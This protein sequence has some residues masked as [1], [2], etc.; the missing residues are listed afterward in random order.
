M[1]NKNI[2][3]FQTTK[4]NETNNFSQQSNLTQKSN[5]G[6]SNSWAI[7]DFANVNLKNCCLYKGVHVVQDFAVR[8]TKHKVRFEK[9]IKGTETTHWFARYGFLVENDVV[10]M[11]AVLLWTHG[12][13]VWLWAF[14]NWVQ[15]LLYVSPGQKINNN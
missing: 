3:V 6:F 15:V 4:T 12:K 1:S 5:A 11:N 2:C 13:Q 14:F 8:C 7:F 10:S 9:F